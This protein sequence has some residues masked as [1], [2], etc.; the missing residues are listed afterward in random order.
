MSKIQQIANV[1]RTEQERFAGESVAEQL[2]WSVWMAWT[3]LG[4]DEGGPEQMSSS[5]FAD[6]CATLNIKRGTAM[7]RYSEARRNWKA[8]NG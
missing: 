8:M 3:E 2:R 5:E 6:A 1:I 7:N 4:G